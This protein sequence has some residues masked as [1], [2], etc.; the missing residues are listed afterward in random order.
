MV[1]VIVLRLFLLFF[2]F[3][4]GSVAP[5]TIKSIGSKKVKTQAGQYRGVLVEFPMT[6]LRPVEAFNGIP[7]ATLR[8]GKLRFIP[9]ASFIRNRNKLI[10][11]SP[12]NGSIV[13]PQKKFDKK[14]F[15]KQM[16]DGSFRRVQRVMSQNH[17]RKEDCLSLSVYV[18][19]I[20]KLSHSTSGAVQQL[21]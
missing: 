3:P 8:D 16:N 7:Y 10:E 11:L 20:G 19:Q 4:N 13:C 6:Q 21:R 17:T 1:S 15:I 9:P 14:T 2:I 18:P 5:V 12:T